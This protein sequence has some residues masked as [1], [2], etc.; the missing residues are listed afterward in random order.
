MDYEE[1]SDE[2][3]D[4]KKGLSTA[5]FIFYVCGNCQRLES[6]ENGWCKSSFSKE[7]YVYESDPDCEKICKSYY[8]MQY[9]NFNSEEK[10]YWYGYNV[11]IIPTKGQTTY[12]VPMI[13]NKQR[14]LKNKHSDLAVKEYKRRLYER[15]LWVSRVIMKWKPGTTRGLPRDLIPWICAYVVPESKIWSYMVEK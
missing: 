8:T 13:D 3:Y 11:N 6:K 9:K 1:D 14:I 15:R 10:F 12:F 7:A 5:D 4:Y 2:I